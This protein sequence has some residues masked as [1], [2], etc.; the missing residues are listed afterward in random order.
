MQMHLFLKDIHTYIILYKLFCY[1]DA[2][3]PEVELSVQVDLVLLGLRSGHPT[4][5]AMVSS[6]YS[7]HCIMYS[8]HCI[9]YSVHCMMYTVHCIMYSVR[10]M[11]Y[12]V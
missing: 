11:M 2:P 3:I 10:C 8:V 9:M 5:S 12:S 7:V 6:L 4:D 1:A